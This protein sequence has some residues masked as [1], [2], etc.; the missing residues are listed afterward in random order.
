LT[1]WGGHHQQGGQRAAAAGGQPAK[2]EPAYGF[3][4]FV[5]AA[6]MQLLQQLLAV[7]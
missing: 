5:E 6:A 1:V 4:A 7:I 2:G 3:I